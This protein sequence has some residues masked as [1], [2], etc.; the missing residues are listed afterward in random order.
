MQVVAASLGLPLRPA[1]STRSTSVVEF[2]K[3]KHLLLV[4]DNCEHL[5][6]AAGDARGAA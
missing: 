1:A 3:G 5:I 2:L 4:L 6:D